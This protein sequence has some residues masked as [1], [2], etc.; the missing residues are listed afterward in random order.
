VLVVVIRGL[1]KAFERKRD[2]EY[3]AALDRK[4]AN[5]SEISTRTKAALAAAKAR[6]KKLGGNRGVTLSREAQAAGRAVQATRAVER[7]ADLE[8]VISDL[9]K[10]GISTLGAFSLAL[11][12]RGI[13]TAREGGSWT[14]T[15]VARV[16]VRINS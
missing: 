2:R 14:P 15:Q 6:G 5:L 1:L 10:R 8:P 3:F 13:P 16:L 4:I 7:A 9:R 12:E 11:N